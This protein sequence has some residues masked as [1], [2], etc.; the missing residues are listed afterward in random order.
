MVTLVGDGLFDL[1]V[2][3]RLH[4]MKTCPFI[5]LLILNAVLTFALAVVIS[6]KQTDK[7][8]I[9]TQIEARHEVEQALANALKERDASKRKI[10]RLEP[11][12]T[13]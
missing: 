4:H 5:V 1:R 7:Y 10:Q 2:A 8:I 12:D 6:S 9:E 11:C 13:A 3:V